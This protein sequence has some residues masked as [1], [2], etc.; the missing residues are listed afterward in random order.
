M[1]QHPIMQKLA[2]K[3]QRHDIPAVSW[4]QRPCAS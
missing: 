3:L 1:S 2:A 4:R